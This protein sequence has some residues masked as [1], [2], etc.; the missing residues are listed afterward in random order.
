MSYPKLMVIALLGAILAGCASK[1]LPD[2]EPTDTTYDPGSDVST[3]G[4]ADD[5]PF[6]GSAI[7]GADEGPDM[8]IYFD[9][10]S[11]DVRA[12]DRD[13]GIASRDDARQRSVDAQCAWKGMPTSVA[14][15]STTS[16][17]VS[18]VPGPC[19]RC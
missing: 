10:D 12:E 3:S 8:V 2:P 18:V 1:P 15:A 11:S 13:T 19:A 9:F 6:G 5:D 17:S 16:V 14:R 7:P 4:T